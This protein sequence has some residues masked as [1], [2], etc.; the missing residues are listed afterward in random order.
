M[1]TRFSPLQVYGNFFKRSRAAN[2][3]VLGRIWPKFEL[4][5]AI[6]VVLVTCKYEED[7]IKNEGARVLTRFFPI[8]TLWKQSVVMET[9]VSIRSGPNPNAAFLHTNDASDK[10]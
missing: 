4:V 9:R 2:S 6:M 10:I 3:V 1:L 5:Q 7:P 8:I